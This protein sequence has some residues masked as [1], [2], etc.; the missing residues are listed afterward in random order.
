MTE[1]FDILKK[2][3]DQI[4]KDLIK[5]HIELGMKSSG[6]WIASLENEV[7][8]SGSVYKAEITGLQYTEQLV[9]GRKPGK[10]PPIKAI[11]EWI[12][13]KGIQPIEKNIKISSLAFLI[14]RS[15]AE[16]GTTYFQ[17]GGT[18]L[19]ESVVTPERIQNIIDQISIVNVNHIVSGLVTKLE[20]FK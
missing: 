12:I 2:E 1:N 3:F 7:V 8:Q 15:I 14:A 9:W 10:F 5:R 16:K 17:Q 20:N 18:D 13:A 4:E 11:E 6:K 19:V